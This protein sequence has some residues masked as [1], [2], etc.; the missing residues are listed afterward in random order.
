MAGFFLS[1]S[2]DNTSPLFT[3]ERC[4][5]SL[6]VFAKKGLSLGAHIVREGFELWY[7]P[8]IK[9]SYDQL[10][11]FPNGDF[12]LYTGTLIYGNK[13]DR[14]ALLGIYEDHVSGIFS[15]ANVSGNYCLIVFAKNKLMVLSDCAG[16]YPVYC[17]STKTVISNSFLAT[18]R[19]EGKPVLRSHEFFE[20]LLFGFFWG[21]ET[22]LEG[23]YV[24]DKKRLWF[25]LTPNENILRKP[26]YEPFPDGSSWQD[27]VDR[28]A[29]DLSDYFQTLLTVFGG[30]IGSAVSG[31]YDTRLM[32]AILRHLGH[33]PYLYV[34]GKDNSSD[35]SVAKQICS[36]EHLSLEHIDK[37][38]FARPSP[39]EF[40][41][42]MERQV[43]FFDGIKPLGIIDDGSDLYTRFDRADK[44]TLQLNGAGGEIY[45]EIWNLSDHNVDL[46]DFLRMRFD[47]G[48][49][50]FCRPSFNETHFFTVLG[51]KVRE[52]LDIDRS[53]L[54]R[55]EAEKLFPFL[56]NYFA[57]TNNAA[58]NQI[59]YSLIPFMEPKFIY[60]SFDI[61]IPYKYCGEFQ[62]KLIKALD[63][64]LA[65]YPSSYG[66]NFFDPVPAKYRLLRMA[67]R[68]IPLKIR[69]LKRSAVKSSETKPYYFNEDYIGNIIDMKNLQISD[70]VD[71]D[72]LDNPELLSRALSVELLLSKL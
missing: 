17:N 31:G 28:V 54:T 34:Y 13:I 38:T 39:D 57:A 72:K 7:F 26:V 63:P 70:L 58:N 30:S 32:L 37:S 59:S 64:A 44:A 11:E 35:V 20:Y 29:A 67:E 2:S 18:A 24:L 21:L 52:I 27:K 48:S 62:A 15:D 12:V 69:L 42:I 9:Q 65:K 25:P 22:L 43:Y 55:I 40:A 1:I 6:D 53:W 71:V 41:A 23:V 45:R 66:I 10:L 36:G 56:R 16:Y 49:Y 4:H 47:R 33:V 5:A 14:D 50:A 60:P 51:N 68:N 3:S 8:K 46:L 19:A 61:P